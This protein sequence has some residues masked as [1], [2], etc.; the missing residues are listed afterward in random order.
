MSS[1]PFGLLGRTL[2]HSYSPQIHRAL[3]GIDYVCF[4]R[5]PKDVEE[6]LGSDSWSGLNVTVPYKKAAFAAMDELTETARRM[7]NVNTIV[8]TPEGKLLGDNTDA[9]GFTCIL[10][11]L[12][13]DVKGKRVLVLGGTGG[14]GTTVCMVLDDLGAEVVPVSRSRGVTYKDLDAYLDAALIVNAT[15]VGMYPNCPDAPLS[16]E[17]FHRLEAVADIVYNP[18]LTGILLEA[19]KLNIPHVNGLLMLVAQAA[20]A[21]E[22]FFGNTIPF[23]RIQDVS[24]RLAAAEKNVALIGMPGSGKTRVG[25]ALAKILGRR[26][27]DIDQELEHELKCPCDRYIRENGEKRFRN[28]ETEVI[29]RI[30]MQSRLVISTGGGAV[31]RPDNYPFLHQNATIC[32]LDRN[33]DELSS[34]GR[35]IT[36]R[37][38]ID[39]LAQQRL[40]LYRA[41]ADIV[42]RS[43]ESPQ[44]T[45]EALAAVLPSQLDI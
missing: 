14:A 33:L 25:I 7:G 39:K 9:Y 22:R 31:T 18:S 27:V 8:R 32:M 11:T 23:E 20:R 30:G 1:A 10:K 43:R 13:C 38:G 29:K 21:D 17:K 6:F 35:P 37:D 45:A 15:P 40:P 41:W 44:A 16:L 42:I 12:D 3:A 28:K 26:H 24:K 4:E 2:K 36:Q 19:E 34:K 5:E